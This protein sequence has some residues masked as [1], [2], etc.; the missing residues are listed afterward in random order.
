M[1][2]D[3]LTIDLLQDTLT[4]MRGQHAPSVVKAIIKRVAERIEQLRK[5]KPTGGTMTI[6]HLRLIQAAIR[7]HPDVEINM[8]DSCRNDLNRCFTQEPD[9]ELSFWYDIPMGEK[10][11]TKTIRESSI[12]GS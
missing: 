6:R 7:R 9:G 8:P 11:S 12:C 5:R 1:N 4:A 3:N 2:C 10:R